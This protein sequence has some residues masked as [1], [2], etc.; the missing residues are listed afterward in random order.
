[1]KVKFMGD[2]LDVMLTNNDELL[3]YDYWRDDIFI[4]NFNNYYLKHVNLRD[5]IIYR[6]VKLKTESSRKVWY[7]IY[8]EYIV[9]RTKER[10]L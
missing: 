8:N 6:P 7:A 4:Y 1:M 2:T 9:A 3:V 5:N 10:D